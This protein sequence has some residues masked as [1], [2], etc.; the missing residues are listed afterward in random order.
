MRLRRASLIHIQM[1]DIHAFPN[2][3]RNGHA[4]VQRSVRV[5]ENDLDFLIKLLFLLAFQGMDIFAA[6]GDGA[7]S[8]RIHADNAAAARRLA[9]AG[10]TDEAQC[11]AGHNLKRDIV[12]GLDGCLA[13]DLKILLE[14]LHFDERLFCRRG[15]LLTA[16]AD[17]LL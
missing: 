14:V 11:F 5:L 3:F 16:Q 17:P 13:A 6:V 7:G 12:H 9:A 10:L 2:D 1:M 8:R 4:G 15:F